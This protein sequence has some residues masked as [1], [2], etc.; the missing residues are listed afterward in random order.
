MSTD[1]PE[2]TTSER[3]FSPWLAVA[4]GVFVVTVGGTL[5][6]YFGQFDR[7]LEQVPVHWGVGDQPDQLVP[8]EKAL[9]YLLIGPGVMLLMLVLTWLLP[10][11]SPWDVERFHDIFQYIMAL[12]VILFAYV[13]ATLVLAAVGAPIPMPRSL[14][15]GIFL[16]FALLGN[17]LGKVRRNFWVGVR[18]PWTLANEKVWNA[19]HRLS[20][21]L[22][23]GLGLVGFVAVLAGVNLLIVMGVFIA[24]IL[25]PI[26][27]SLVLYKRLERTGQLE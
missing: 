15:A 4:I 17:V 9:P 21:W 23:L 22:F 10:W 20:A 18:T 26:I 1:S 12:M 2:T 14:V 13:Q 16:F 3:R 7:L 19:T 8:K 25:W 5:Y 24:A 27:Y 11:L 6:L